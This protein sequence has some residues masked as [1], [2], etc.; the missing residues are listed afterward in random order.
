MKKLLALAMALALCM[1]LTVPALADDVP[2]P[3]AAYEEYTISGASDGGGRWSISFD[4]AKAERRP[5]WLRYRRAIS[6]DGQWKAV[7]FPYAMT[8][9]TLVTL[10][11]GSGFQISPEGEVPDVH[12]PLVY[13]AY[14]QYTSGSDF[15]SEGFT[16][17]LF[18]GLRVA[19]DL[20]HYG[21]IRVDGEDGTYLIMYAPTAGP[22]DPGFSD[23]TETATCKDAVAWAAMKNIT[24]GVTASTFRPDDVCTHNHILTFL[25]RASGAPAA[26]GEGDFDKAVNWARSKGILSG[27]SFDGGAACT[28]SEAMVYLWT[29][30]GSPRVALDHSFIDVAAIAD[31]GEA[32][33]WAVRQGITEGTSATTFSPNDVCTRGQ[34]VNFLYRAMK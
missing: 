22:A 2:G 21:G 24:R 17:N 11:P 13:D 32:V 9:V 20:N 8:V 7:F 14:N 18:D 33:V 1:G 27:D 4:A 12:E 25:W 23:V 5:V 15:L 19:W 16:S 26:E 30:A 34:I 31:Y 28:R 10:E 29:L 3:D 6:F